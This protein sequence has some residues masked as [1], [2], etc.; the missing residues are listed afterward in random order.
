VAIFF[1]LS[2]FCIHLSYE[3]SKPGGIGPYAVRRFFRIYPSF[4]I[5]LLFF[6]L[7]FPPTRLHFDSPDD[8]VQLFSRI[9][10][11]HNLDPSTFWGI[12]GV[13]WSVAVEVQL[14]VLY[15]ILL[16][17]S[18]RRWGWNR[19]I[20][21][22][23]FLEL[24]LRSYVWFFAITGINWELSYLFTQGP[25]A[26]MFS[27]AIGAKLASD[28][29]A[30][31]KL[32]LSDI[33]LV[34]WLGLLLISLFFKPMYVFAFPLF[35]LCAVSWIARSLTTGKY[36][37]PLP[38]M[39]NAHLHWVGLLSYSMY[40]LHQPFLN[41][42]PVL[43]QSAFPGEFIHPIY[44]LLA[45]LAM[46]PLILFMSWVFY[47]YVELPSIGAGKWLIRMRMAGRENLGKDPA[48]Q[49]AFG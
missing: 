21:L 41:V 16:L 8:F 23:C 47:R 26:Y 27:W 18:V 19:T 9:F 43:L 40:L 34:L 7:L 14:Y 49:S 10:L 28:M 48:R 6:A 11:V 13:F 17:Y 31:R 42:A 35:S 32:F 37:L 46:Y 24:F 25:L 3:R 5:A 29:L 44:K 15:P 12:N 2:G 36:L 45:C 1:A 33:P 4:L 22:T 20:L 38:K 30:N 39:L